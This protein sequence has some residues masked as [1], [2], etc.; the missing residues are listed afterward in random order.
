MIKVSVLK[1]LLNTQ[2]AEIEKLDMDQLRLMLECPVTSHDY[3][4]VR[5]MNARPDMIFLRKNVVTLRRPISLDNKIIS[6]G[7]RVSN[8]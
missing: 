6:I 2:E 8:K 7:N 1:R 4:S 3:S 5:S